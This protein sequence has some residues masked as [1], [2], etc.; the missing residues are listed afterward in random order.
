MRL[1]GVSR[2][3]N[4]RSVF[5]WGW[6]KTPPPDVK[7]RQ[8][9]LIPVRISNRC[10]ARTEACCGAHQPEAADLRPAARHLGRPVTSVASLWVGD[11][12]G[13]LE[14]LSAQSFVETGNHLTIY[15]YG[16]LAD[17]PQG[18]RVADAEPIF[19]GKRI[20]RYPDTGSPSV[21]ANLFR[22]EMMRRTGEV[23]VDLDIFALRPFAFESP[24]VFAWE[25]GGHDIINNALL[26]LPAAS[27]T[28][29]KL[30]TMQP[31]TVGIPPKS[32]FLNRPWLFV[33][34]LGRGVGI[35]R[36]GMGA[37]GPLALTQY[38]R[39]TGE[40]VHALAAE[41][42]YPL[43]WREAERFVAPGGYALSEAAGGAYGVHFYASE[44]RRIMAKKFSSTVPDGSFLA[45]A[46]S[47]VGAPNLRD[48]PV[49]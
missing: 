9:V 18:V 37:T 34:T 3:A 24:F 12:L 29:A 17:V 21:H 49:D 15:T 36:W 31:D 39:D 26:G 40:Y 47:R 33:S 38:L 48:V 45:E 14:I 20:L 16:G 19:S 10:N 44:L 8:I 7:A 23:W 25:D 5:Q 13:P 11:R 22:H 2:V 27:K 42:I 35:E 41:A 32:T 43:H 1:S 30:L 46:M 6:G 28:L 4:H